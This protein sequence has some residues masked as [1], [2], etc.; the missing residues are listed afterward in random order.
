MSS[1]I[2]GGGRAILS[3]EAEE[4]I[5]S[6][7]YDSRQR[8]NPLLPKDE[9]G[10][11]DADATLDDKGN[12][13]CFCDLS[14]ED[15]K[16]EKKKFIKRLV[17]CHN[18]QI[19]AR[20]FNG[21]SVDTNADEVKPGPAGTKGVKADSTPNKDLAVRNGTSDKV[22]VEIVEAIFKDGG[23][24]SKSKKSKS[25][26]NSKK[27]KDVLTWKEGTRKT[28]V[29]LRCTNIKDFMTQC[30]S[31]L[32]MK[33][34]TRVFYVDKNSKLEIDLTNDL[35]G[36]HDGAVV[37]VTSHQEK[38][39]S[40]GTKPTEKL[41][42]LESEEDL[43][44]VDPLE[45]VKRAYNILQKRFAIV[46]KKRIVNDAKP[47]FTNHL[48]NL[49]ELSEERSRLP[50]SNYRSDILASLDTSRVVV[51]CGATGKRK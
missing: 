45:S 33:K 4:M 6:L 5:V 49:D 50:A 17:K 7:L 41:D 35:S 8:E 10:I 14:K 25:I 16:K 11:V 46:G 44:L 2:K 21:K 22:R 19:L 48:Q 28:I 15:K 36:L 1:S 12:N 9:N 42:E 39:T 13:R 18:Q 27:S 37:Y 31:K 40:S 26:S 38:D 23:K 29:L 47:P 43:V 51:I 24:H 3:P 34:P 20:K 32:K 30:K